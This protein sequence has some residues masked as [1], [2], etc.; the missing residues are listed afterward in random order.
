MSIILNR[1][2]EVYV[3]NVTTDTSPG[4]SANDTDKISITKA[5]SLEHRVNTAKVDSQ[6]LR[7]QS[8]FL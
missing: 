2:A 7:I 3:S 6:N 4:P 5:Y 1:N 8:I